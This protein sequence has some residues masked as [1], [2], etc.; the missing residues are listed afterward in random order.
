LYAYSSHRLPPTID[1]EPNIYV[2]VAMG[3]N[4]TEYTLPELVELWSKK[5]GAIGLREY[6]GVEAWDWGLP[7]RMRGSQVDYHRKWIPHYVKRK[8]NAINAETNANWGGQMLGLY[9]AAE[10][11]WNADAD[12]DALVAGYFKDCY[13]PAAKP[14]RDLQAKFDAAA[15]LRPATLKPMFDDVAR[16]MELADSDASRAR[17]ADMMA[18]LVYVADYRQFEMTA[19][20]RPSRDEVYY[21]ALGPLMTY[22]WRIRG[23]DMVH[24]HALARRLCNGLPKTDN[25]LDFWMYNKEQTPVW[26]V[27]EP[28]TD[29]QVLAMF[30]DHRERLGTDAD[31]NVI[32]S[33]YLDRVRPA[34]ADAG[35]SRLAT[36]GGDGEARFR[37]TTTGYL[38][39]G[40]ACE[41]TIG[42]Q[43]T[44]R[45]A[46]LT[47]LG[48]GDDVLFEKEFRKADTF[49]DAVISL[50]RGGEHR[51]RLE[52]DAVIRVG[53][54]V[55]LVYEAS[56]A[57]PAWVDY[58]GPHYFYVPR[59]ATEI[60]VEANPRL[61]LYLPG[62]GKRVDIS[63]EGAVEGQS[64]IVV[65]VPEGAAGQ[66][67]HT[68]VQTRG[69]FMLLNIPPLLSL[70][71]QTVF[72]PREVAEA[73]QLTTAETTGAK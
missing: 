23:R 35:P 65:P 51:F 19:N 22:A 21:E 36:A 11:M 30:N 42:V 8:M 24:Y 44:G 69:R 47:V 50:P 58:S 41:V 49:S 66:V 7:G 15:P 55:P 33:R 57:N 39:P 38:V 13:G 63:P 59:G 3:F 71:R 54:D 45:S 14:M 27:G 32:F 5:V 29:A 56:V 62:N 17:I 43:A 68:D 70:H 16:A 52:G 53:P 26:Q 1:L 9:V 72:V 64:Y 28:L 46:K 48:R 34:G 31:P 25:R 2:Q 10:L 73:D 40:A 67:W 6:Y 60:I 37:G 61:S 4:R 20:R 12:V 18:Y